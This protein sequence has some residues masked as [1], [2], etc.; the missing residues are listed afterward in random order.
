MEKRIRVTHVCYIDP[1]WRCDR[2][3]VENG[4]N[5]RIE[6]NL[7]L[8]HVQKTLEWERSWKAYRDQPQYHFMGPA[9][10]VRPPP[11]PPCTCNPL[12]DPV[13]LLDDE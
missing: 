11:M 5:M 4:A 2:E 6:N 7:F 10:L 9:P 8:W 13:V 3:R 1:P 12:L